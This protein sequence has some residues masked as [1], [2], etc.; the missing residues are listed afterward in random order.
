MSAFIPNPKRQRGNNTVH[1]TRPNPG[2]FGYMRIH[3]IVDPN[4]WKGTGFVALRSVQAEFFELF[5]E[6]ISVDTHF[7]GRLGLHSPRMFHHLQNQLFFD[8]A[9]NSL[10]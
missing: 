3:S 6:G 7:G 9:D 5:V 2:E 4:P 10:V 1:M 8:T